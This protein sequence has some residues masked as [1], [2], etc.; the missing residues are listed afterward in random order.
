MEIQKSPRCP[1][2]ESQEWAGVAIIWSNM[3][4]GFGLYGERGVPDVLTPAHLV[5]RAL[6]YCIIKADICLV[7]LY[8]YI[9]E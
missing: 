9:E 6:G 7:L 4:Q 2:I 8:V 3:A 5:I 1:L